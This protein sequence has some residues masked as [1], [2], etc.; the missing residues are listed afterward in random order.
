MRLTAAAALLAIVSATAASAQS[1]GEVLAMGGQCFLSAAGQRSALKI[2]DAVH[3]GDSVDVP[4][5]AKL[6]LRMADGT[7]IS[8]AADSHL[9]INQ[10]ALG[11][12]EKRDAR[13][14]LA[15][16]LLR[17]V[18][19]AVGQP[20]KFEVSTATGVAAVRSTDWFIEA[21]PGSAQ[22]GV[23]GGEVAFSSVATGKTVEIPARWGSRIEMGRDP[24]PARVWTKAEF[25]AVIA[26]T[27]VP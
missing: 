2:G 13:F 18:V 14:D 20:Q 22:V 16:G 23:L 11:G 3:V 5:G 17:A 10:Y 6:K 1:V 7:I 21:K 24:V 15:N 27:N 19:T 9:T 8:V 25:D 12:T 4:Q 26:R